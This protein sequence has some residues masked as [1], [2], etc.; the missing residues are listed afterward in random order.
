M[1]HSRL[2]LHTLHLPPRTGEWKE[3]LEVLARLREGGIPVGRVP[4]LIVLRLLLEKRR[5]GPAQ[6]VLDQMDEQKQPL[7]LETARL[8]LFSLAKRGPVDS[9]LE[10]LKMMRSKGVVPD[11]V[12][13]TAVLRGQSVPPSLASPSRV[14]EE[15]R[16]ADQPDPHVLGSLCALPSA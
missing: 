14:R 15:V 6:K 10:F 11:L 1:T 12:C 9:S 8:V 3:C 16:S 2:T 5:V 4:F 7:D 13:Y